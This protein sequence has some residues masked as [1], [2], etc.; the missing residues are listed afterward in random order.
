MSIALLPMPARRLLELE[1]DREKSDPTALER[2]VSDTFTRSGMGTPFPLRS[3]WWW[4]SWSIVELQPATNDA[5]GA[6]GTP[7]A[8]LSFP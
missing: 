5:P 7:P 1:L 2:K 6:P 3:L 8:N 4:A